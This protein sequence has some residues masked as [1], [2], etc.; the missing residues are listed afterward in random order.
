MSFDP[1]WISAVAAILAVGFSIWAHRSAE[2]SRKRA[3]ALELKNAELAEMQ[4]RLAH[5]SWSDEYFREITTWACNVAT[6]ISRAIHLVG[7]DDEIARRETLVTLSACIDMGRWYFPNRDHDK[8]GQTKEPAFRGVRQPCL[9][10]VVLAYD[11]C[12]G[13]R[14]ANDSRGLL[15]SCQR[16]FVSCIQEVLDPRSRE[17]AIERV[18]TDFGA[19][20]TLPKVK[21]PQ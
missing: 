21:S 20:A 1:N 8:Q 2:R 10:W 6:A 14:S 16:N 11:I 19:I 15:V 7:I 18:L 9:D 5:Q 3:D 17:R 13:Q 12:S 4:N